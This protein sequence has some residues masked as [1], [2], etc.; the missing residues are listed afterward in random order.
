MPLLL[1]CPL[2]PLAQGA[3]CIE[4]VVIEHIRMRTTINVLAFK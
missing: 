2:Q 1:R 3:I 4:I